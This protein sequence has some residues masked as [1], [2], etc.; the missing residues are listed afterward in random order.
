[1]ASGIYFRLLNGKGTKMSGR[2]N[3][4]IYLTNENRDIIKSFS[5]LIGHFHRQKL[6]R[7]QTFYN[8]IQGR[9]KKIN[10]RLLINFCLLTGCKYKIKSLPNGKLAM[11]IS[12]PE[13]QK[14]IGYHK[15]CIK[16]PIYYKK[17][18]EI[19][20]DKIVDEFNIKL[21]ERIK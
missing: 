1:M 6:I 20:V 8:W 5:Y 7:K 19:D 18:N 15:G 21:A 14:D 16:I 11:S 4:S 17:H 3:G 10:K 12:K 9:N 2:C 13:K